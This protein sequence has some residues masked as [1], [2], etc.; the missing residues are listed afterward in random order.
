MLQNAEY[1]I[2][3]R[4]I[5]NDSSTFIY[6]VTCSQRLSCWFKSM[7]STQY[8]HITGNFI[9]AITGINAKYLN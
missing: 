3:I 4:H 8:L 9:C 2:P 7:Y 1:T 5:S 6:H